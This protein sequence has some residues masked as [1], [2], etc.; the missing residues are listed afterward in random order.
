V[1]RFYGTLLWCFT[2]LSMHWGF[3]HWRERWVSHQVSLEQVVLGQHF[4]HNLMEP[5]CHMPV[6][7][8]DKP[9]SCKECR[10][11]NLLF[12]LCSEPSLRPYFCPH[13]LSLLPCFAFCSPLLAS[14][15]HCS[16]PGYFMPQ[17]MCCIYRTKKLSFHHYIITK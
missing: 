11:K 12:F 4:S 15:L 13:N 5:S 17:L 16:E 8:K 3:H 2:W 10:A 1:E 6:P 14:H 9:P 7:H